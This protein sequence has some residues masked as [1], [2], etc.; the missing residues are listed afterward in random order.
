MYLEG[1]EDGSNIF[2]MCSLWSYDIETLIKDIN[3][4]SNSECLKVLHHIYTE[5]ITHI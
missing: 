4:K 3:M 2:S 1:I 5:S